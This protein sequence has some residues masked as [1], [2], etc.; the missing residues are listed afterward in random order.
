MYFNGPIWGQM[1]LNA[2]VYITIVR[3]SKMS[4]REQD[5]AIENT[6]RVAEEAKNIKDKHD[7]AQTLQVVGQ[8]QQQLAAVQDFQRISQ[9]IR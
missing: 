6:Q 2:S 3:R 8:Q 1:P 7:A 9:I 4:K 5:K